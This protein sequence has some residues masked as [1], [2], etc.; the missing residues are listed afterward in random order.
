MADFTPDQDYQD[1][2]DI[3]LARFQFIH[4]EIR[5]VHTFLIFYGMVLM[6]LSVGFISHL[7]FHH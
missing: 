7:Y 6:A 1:Y 5:K 4:T 3:T 2:H